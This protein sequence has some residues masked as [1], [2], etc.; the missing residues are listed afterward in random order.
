MPLETSAETPVPVRTV[1]R[2]VGD[3]I[4]RLG[5]VWV[6]GQIAELAR[7]GS[8]VFLVVR[9]PV[10]A[11][12]VRV[13]CTTAVLDATS[14]PPT[15]GS[16][17]VIFARPEF[18]AAKGSFALSAAQIRSVGIGD[19]LARIERLRTALAAEGLFAAE[20]KRQL[21]FLPRSVGLI[22]GRDSAA[23]RDVR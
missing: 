10:A 5:R 1:L 9:D 21:P 4:G 19:L 2:L 13:I 14:P 15:E 6:E 20:R 18:N 17:V 23:E 3:W 8:T 11:V 16:R 22:C 7:R 12:S